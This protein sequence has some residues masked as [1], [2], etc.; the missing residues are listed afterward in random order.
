[1]QT[2]GELKPIRR[3]RQRSPDTI[4]FSGL[5]LSKSA[6]RRLDRKAAREGLS[7]GAAITAILEAWVRH[8][9][10]PPSTAA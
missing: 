6:A 9:A 1:M 4:K 8:G 2:V 5:R 3:Y 10:K 7:R